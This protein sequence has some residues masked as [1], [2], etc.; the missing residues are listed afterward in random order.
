MRMA[1]ILDWI[2]GQAWNDPVQWRLDPPAGVSMHWSRIADIPVAAAVSVLS[3]P[4]GRS[5]AL[6]VAAFAVPPVLG[7]LFVALFVWAARGLSASAFVAPF[8]MSGALVMP[9][10]QFRP[11]RID[12]HGLQ[13]VLV[14]VA[15]GFLFRCLRSRSPGAASGAGVAAA[16]SL[17]VGLEMLPFVAACAAI[18]CLAWVLRRETAPAL[19]AFAATLACALVVL[20]PVTVPSAEWSVA[21]CDRMSL[22]HLSAAAVLAAAG[23]AAWLAG[24]RAATAGVRQRG[25]AVAAGAVATAALLWAA[26]PHCAGGPYAEVAPEIRYWLDRVNEARSLA[27]YFHDHPG[28]A[29]GQAALP[30]TALVYAALF[31]VR[32]PAG[33]RDPRHAALFLLAST[34]AVLLAWQVRNTSYAALAAAFALVPLAAAA[35]ARIDRVRRLL[36][37]VGLRACIPLACVGCVLLPPLVQFSLTNEEPGGEPECDA[38]AM[39]SALTDPGGF[40]SARRTVAAPIDLGPFIL[41]HTPHRVLAAPYHRNV[42]GLADNRV[43][44]AGTGAAALDAIRRRGVDAVLFCSRYVRATAFPGSAGFLNER[45][46]ADNP[47]RW[48]V[49]LAD[50]AGISLYRVDLEPDAAS[51]RTRPA[52]SRSGADHGNERDGFREATH[53]E[54]QQD[55]QWQGAGVT[56]KYRREAVT[57]TDWWGW[58][59]QP[60]HVRYV[61]GLAS[62]PHMDACQEEREEGWLQD[63]K[64]TGSSPAPDT[65]LGPT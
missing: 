36:P 8:T 9:L 28:A 54:Q 16:A 47:P 57:R 17:A 18:L 26:F 45:L 48:L 1:R 25:A 65:G 56:T 24:R 22:P 35:N 62:F 53:D 12:H 50:E 23:A 34:G 42:A 64:T 63:G 61:R 29:A 10:L 60:R 46:A 4:L 59:P 43:V 27:R 6:R 30:L 5:R 40:G 32:P 49:P 33:R 15:A 7:G 51:R 55:T 37:R 39:L 38:G 19:A 14:T 44:F 21:A 13:L 3:G 41:L 2:D 31:A 20:Y 52:A 11:G 58:N